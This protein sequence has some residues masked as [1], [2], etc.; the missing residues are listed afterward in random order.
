MPLSLP[1]GENSWRNQ[2]QNKQN[3]KEQTYQWTL[4]IHYIL[5]KQSS[6]FVTKNQIK[7]ST[8]TMNV[9]LVLPPSHVIVS[10]Q[11]PGTQTW[12]RGSWRQHTKNK[13]LNNITGYTLCL[14]IVLSN[15]GTW[16]PF[17]TSFSRWWFAF[18]LKKCESRIFWVSLCQCCWCESNLPDWPEGGNFSQG[19]RA[20]VRISALI[21]IVHLT[22]FLDV[23]ADFKMGHMHWHW[24]FWLRVMICQAKLDP[25]RAAQF[26]LDLQATG[27]SFL[28]IPVDKVWRLLLHLN[29]KQAD[30]VDM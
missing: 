23:L 24:V 18:I 3:N 2:N 1:R 12:R 4:N 29:P 25:S 21:Q 13:I 26:Q 27:H 17:S 30:K 28:W 11:S 5:A 9:F 19:T 8:V 15:H 16:D 14:L 22:L 20:A 6:C 10:F 7:N